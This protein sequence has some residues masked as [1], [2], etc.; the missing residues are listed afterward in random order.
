MKE[1]MKYF[2]LSILLLGSMTAQ[3]QTVTMPDGSTRPLGDMDGDGEVNI[4]D[5]TAL[6]NKIL[7]KTP[8]PEPEPEPEPTRVPVLVCSDDHHPT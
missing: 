6:V 1:Q 2:V 4:S 3:A 5:V 7:G 8:V